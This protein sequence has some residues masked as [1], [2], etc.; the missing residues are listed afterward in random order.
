[1]SLNRSLIAPTS[2]PLLERALIEKLQHRC[3]AAGS[4]G[5]LEPVSVRLGLMQNTLRPRFREPQLVLF[6]ADHG[7]A[8]ERIHA[9]QPLQSHELAQMLVEG[10][11]PL[12]VFARQLGL[13][14]NVVDCGMA[15]TLPQHEHL[16]SRKIAHGTRNARVGPAMALEQAHASIRAG[17]EIGDA[18]RGNLVACA[19]LGECSH[20]AAALIIARLTQTPLRDL[21]VS[22]PQM[23]ADALARAM[24]I[25][26]GA[27]G[28]HRDVTD[29]IEVLAAFGGFE[30]GVMVGVM[31][32]AASKRHV[33][34]VDG[35]AACAAL[36][37]ASQIASSVTDYCVFCRS[38][39]HR[40]LDQA[41]NLFG[42]S[43]LLELGLDT[44]DGTG[45]CMAWPLLRTAAA[46]LS[47]VAEGEDPGPSQPAP[48]SESGLAPLSGSTRGSGRLT[49]Y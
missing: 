47:D 48:M 9:P 4:L 22:G 2:N 20:E 45:A 1:M 6:A 41:L 19:G 18:M 14:L 39:S 7:L 28:R 31:L 33:I 46:L 16:L 8:V 27:H 21:M 37:I 12:A 38:Q 44:L 3:D 17:M 10:R 23:D 34:M 25:L 35:M 26:L 13:E 43:A 15:N 29:P 49:N 24:V 42:A 11:Q 5:E 32:V 30:T 40:G 36:M